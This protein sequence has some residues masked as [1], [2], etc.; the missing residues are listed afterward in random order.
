MTTFTLSTP[1]PTFSLGDRRTEPARAVWEP[2]AA[3]RFEISE[4]GANFHDFARLFRDH[5]KCPD[6][7]FLDGGRG[8]GIYN[9]EMGRNDWSWHGGYGPMFGAVE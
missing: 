2:A 4:N 3:A 9:S 5:L 7:L 1:F 6:A 8:V